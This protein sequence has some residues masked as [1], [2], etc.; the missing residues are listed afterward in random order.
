MNKTCLVFVVLLD[1]WALLL[2]FLSLVVEMVQSFSDRILM[3]MDIP[4]F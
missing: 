3:G 4:T 2:L 1:S